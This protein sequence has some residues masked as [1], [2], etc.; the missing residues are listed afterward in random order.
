MYYRWRA[1][2]YFRKFCSRSPSKWHQSLQWAALI[3]T[4]CLLASS[5]SQCQTRSFLT[6]FFRRLMY[7]ISFPMNIL[8]ALPLLP[9]LIVKKSVIIRIN[10]R[11][12]QILSLRASLK[13]GAMTTG[14]QLLAKPR[15]SVR[16]L[17]ECLSMDFIHWGLWLSKTPINHCRGIYRTSSSLSGMNFINSSS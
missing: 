15:L 5:N 11:L 14:C 3:S 13:A 4:F 1:W 7:L 17:M 8:L 6:A 12:R 16:L 9:K 10:L 2:F